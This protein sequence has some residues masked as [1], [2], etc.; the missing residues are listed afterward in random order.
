MQGGPACLAGS[1][2]E[3]AA[4]GF[5]LVLLALI[6][7]INWS[8]NLLTPK[9]CPQRNGNRDS[10]MP[11][12]EQRTKREARY[13]GLWAM[14]AV[15]I[16]SAFVFIDGLYRLDLTY[17][18]GFLALSAAILS[19]IW[20]VVE[21]K[22]LLAVAATIAM[23][24]AYLWMVSEIQVPAGTALEASNNI[25]AINPTFP[26]LLALL[27]VLGGVATISFYLFMRSR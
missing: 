9:T 26:A 15:I 27:Y 19:L 21:H 4:L 3:M 24:S 5:I 11:Y 20:L 16:A 23:A 22:L 7:A 12:W 18:A 8:S 1:R 13:V 17:Q 14:L 25:K 2:V 6:V 10:A